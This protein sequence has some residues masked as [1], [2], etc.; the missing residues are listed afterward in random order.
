LRA[1]G[2]TTLSIHGPN[3]Y[4]DAEAQVVT[5]EDELADA[6]RLADLL[7]AT[8]MTLHVPRTS[9][10]AMAPEGKVWS[11]FL[12]VHRRCL[13]QVAAAGITI[14]I[15]NLHMK[16]TEPADDRRG[17]GYLPAECLAWIAAVQ[18]ALPGARIG[19]HLDIGHART[20]PP[21]MSTW[22]LGRWYAEAGQHVVG[23]HVHQV[24]GGKA[25]RPMH[26]LF[27]PQLSLASFFW[28]WQTG[29]LA[30]GPMFLEIR[31]ESPRVSWDHLQRAIRGAYHDH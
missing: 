15:E 31:G 19:L 17:F 26:T 27:G 28:A 29:Q 13:H 5:G 22:T 7:G 8:Y 2:G 20:N 3:L 21:F 24:D 12:E 11:A 14:G 10:A 9:V 30:R 4:W 25:H 6:L 23:Y 16:R 1:A 18:D